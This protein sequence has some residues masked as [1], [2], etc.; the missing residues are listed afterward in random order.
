VL[1]DLTHG[2]DAL[3]AAHG[4]EKI[5]TIGDCYM[6]VAGVPEQLPDHAARM[7]RMALAMREVGTRRRGAPG[8][9]CRCASALPPGRSWRG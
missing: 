9:T 6:A 2:F 4:V 5:K 7:A 3:A 8:L 1:N